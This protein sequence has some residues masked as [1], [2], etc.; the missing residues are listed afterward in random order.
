[1]NYTLELVCNVATAKTIHPIQKP[2]M[3]ELRAGDR[4]FNNDTDSALVRE[5]GA[6]EMASNHDSILLDVTV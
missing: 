3:T 6:M 1:M 2:L 4:F 5:K